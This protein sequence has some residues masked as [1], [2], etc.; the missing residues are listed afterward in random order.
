MPFELGKKVRK[1][2]LLYEKHPN[3]CYMD[4]GA[5]SLKPKCVIEKMNEYYN[6]YGVNIHRGVYHLSYKAT[7]EVDKARNKVAK[8]INSSFEEVIFV[9][10]ASEALNLC[11]LVYG[12]SLNEGDEIIT[13]F[14][15]HHSSFLPWLKNS[16]EKKTVLKF[17]PLDNEG[18]IT[19]ENFKSVLT[20]K[21]RVVALTYVSNVMGYVTPI[22][23][24]IK[25]AHEKGAIVI[26]DAAQ[27][28]AHINVDVKD[29]DCDFLAF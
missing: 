9:R 13:S 25:L 11:S 16:Q 23:E 14:L 20:D 22:K 10:N 29:L 4:N 21:T 18:R 8:F 2:F 12:K 24:I 6:D 26:V 17:V 7:D 19:I 28:V 5:T 1:D 3:I 27:A 15:E